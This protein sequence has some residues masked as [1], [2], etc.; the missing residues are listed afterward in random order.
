[1]A[2]QRKTVDLYELVYDYGYGDGPEVI[3]SY[4]T[5]KGAIIDKKAYIEN[6]GIYPIIKRRRIRKEKLVV[7]G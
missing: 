3:A 5:M 7:H 2:Y 1:M 4:D 6:E